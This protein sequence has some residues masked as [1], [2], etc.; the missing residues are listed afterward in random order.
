MRCDRV[1]PMLAHVPAEPVGIESMHALCSGPA[2]QDREQDACSPYSMAAPAKTYRLS[3]GAFSDP[4]PLSAALRDL[5]GQGMSIASLCLI[6]PRDVLLD[7]GW[8]HGLGTP[9]APFR[10]LHASIRAM[11]GLFDLQSCAVTTGALFDEVFETSVSRCDGLS[12]CP[13]WFSEAQYSRL[14]S[15]IRSGRVVL[16]VSS[17]SPHQQDASTRS[18]LRHSQHGVQTHDFT[19][20]AAGQDARPGRGRA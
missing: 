14:L 5:S 3:I 1:Q 4:G 2:A 16:L 13:A 11:P 19:L 18:L 12:T 10:S 9:D 17:E 20:H 7:N 15:N 8:W 6:G